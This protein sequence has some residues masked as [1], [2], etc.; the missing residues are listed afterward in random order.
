MF[1]LTNALFVV[2]CSMKMKRKQFCFLKSEISVFDIC[3][4]VQWKWSE[5]NFAFWKV[6]SMFLMFALFCRTILL[7]EKWDQ[8]FGYLLYIAEQFCFLKSE[9]IVFDI[10]SILQNVFDIC[11]IL[12]VMTKELMVF[13]ITV[14]IWNST[15]FIN[16]FLMK[17]IMS[18]S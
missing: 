14:K 1:E 12:Q 8:C 6:R 15:T 9:I 2:N 18:W 16:L 4:I 5:N 17:W 10:C 3:S 11:S 7:F 13:G